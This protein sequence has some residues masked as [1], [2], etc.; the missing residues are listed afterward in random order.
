MESPSYLFSKRDYTGLETTFNKISRINLKLLH[1]PDRV[2]TI[3]ARIQSETNDVNISNEA[4]QNDVFD[5]TYKSFLED[6]KYG[7]NL[8]VMTFVW[9]YVLF[10]Y[11]LIQFDQ[12]YIPGDIYSNFAILS[13]AD[14]FGVLCFTQIKGKND[15]NV[16]YFRSALFTLIFSLILSIF[17]QHSNL[18]SSYNAQIFIFLFLTRMFISLQKAAVFFSTTTLFPPLLR[19]KAFQMVNMVSRFACSFTSPLAAVFPNVTYVITGL[20]L[21]SLCVTRFWKMEEFEE[22]KINEDPNVKGS[23]NY[24]SI[25]QNILDELIENNEKN[26]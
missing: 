7:T 6:K 18:S 15:F 20:S 22:G 21:I 12:D 5:S 16:F 19:G 17:I 23:E 10:S 3:V 9:T 1:D 4:Q 8:A 25:S 2:Q 24:E 13:I 14:S 26:P 11:Y